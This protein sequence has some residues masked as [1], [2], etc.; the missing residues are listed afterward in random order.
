[1]EK[2]NYKTEV[3]FRVD[4]AGAFKGTVFAML[5]HECADLKGNV[6]CYEHVGQHHSADYR[7]CISKSRPA[8]PE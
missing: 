5:P 8:T 4:K 7:G 6:T 3:V 2:D 1:M